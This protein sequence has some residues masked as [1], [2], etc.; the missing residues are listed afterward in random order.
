MNREPG[1]DPSES[2]GND[3]RKSLGSVP[4]TRPGGRGRMSVHL[5]RDM[6]NLHRLVISMSSLVED[7]ID[8]ATRVLC[9]RRYEYA[10]EVINTDS[11]VDER[12]VIVEEECLK[13]LALHQ[14][15]ASDLRRV[16]SVMKIN[17]DLERIADLAVNIADRSRCL[18]EFPE[19]QVPDRTEQMVALT[20][21]M[22]HGVLDAFVALDVTSARRIIRLDD[23]VDEHNREIIQ[24]LQTRMHQNPQSIT[25][26]LHCF[27]AVRH[28][29]RIADHAVNIAEDVI[30]L[31]EGEIVRHRHK[32]DA[33]SNGA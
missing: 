19:F 27:S 25:S 22:V 33:N 30:Y 6:E 2:A 28:I 4:V 20:T 16:T 8:K 32:V 17:Y 13:I 9:E 10:T 1:S 7:M 21:Q 24:E 5:H 15:V 14:P 12:E 18:A 31:V 26:G 29:E 3:S 11:I 23:A